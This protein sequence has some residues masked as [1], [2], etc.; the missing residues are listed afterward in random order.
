MFDTK[1]QTPIQ[2]KVLNKAKIRAE[3][4]GFSSVN[5]VIRILLKQFGEGAID[6]TVTKN[7]N[8][9]GIPYV[10]DEEQVE[11]E[12]VLNNMSEDDLKIVESE[13]VSVKI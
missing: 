13:T 11:L 12:K 6:I 7:T 5:D 2:T 8:S 10:S 4:I 9:K 1:V 3:E